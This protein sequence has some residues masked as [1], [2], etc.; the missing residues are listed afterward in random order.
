MSATEIPLMVFGREYFRIDPRRAALI[1]VD[2]QNSFVAEGAA[3]S[4]EEARQIVPNIDRLI[5]AARGGGLPVIWTQSDMSAPAAGIIHDRH[6]IIKHTK[7]LWRG[8]WSFSFYPRMEP[9]ADGEHRVIKHKYDAFHNTDLDPVLR[10]QGIDTVVIVGVTT[11]C[12]CESTARAAFF[13]DYKV[14]FVRDAMASLDPAAHEQACDRVDL[15]FGRAVT[16]DDVIAVIDSG[17]EEPAA[18]I[19]TAAPPN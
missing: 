8:D 15:L 19:V 9:P 12:C 6:P 4:T 5:R 16:T 14:V 13:R 2:M 3:F 17:R 11:E 10:N 7:E 1:V 18:E